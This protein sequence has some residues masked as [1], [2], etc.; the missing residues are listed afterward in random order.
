MTLDKF[1]Q[2]TER[3]DYHMALNRA[4][5]K[6]ELLILPLNTREQLYNRGIRSDG[7]MVTPKYAQSTIVRKRR[8]GQPYNRVTLRDTGEF[9]KSFQIRYYATSI[10]FV[11][12]Y[13]EKIVQAWLEDRYGDN[14]YGLTRNNIRA[15]KAIILPSLT[16]EF[17]SVT[18]YGQ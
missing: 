13:S 6:N 2:A 12:D 18:K 8:K 5:E 11:S 4:I 14:I 10:R 3:F 17:R 7:R 15:M 1:I 16:N 9:H